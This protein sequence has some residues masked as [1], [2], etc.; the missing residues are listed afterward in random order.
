MSSPDDPYITIPDPPH[1]ENVDAVPGLALYAF[2]AKILATGGT[3]SLAFRA[4]GSIGGG[5]TQVN[6]RPFKSHD[7]I[8]QAAKAWLA[9]YLHGHDYILLK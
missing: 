2:A 7:W 5:Y 9:W 8:S 3:T 1:L 4:S 6:W